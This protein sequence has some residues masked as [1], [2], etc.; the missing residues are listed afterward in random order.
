MDGFALRGADNDGK[1]YFLKEAVSGGNENPKF[2]DN[3]VTIETID[4]RMY[5]DDPVLTFEDSMVYG[6]TLDLNLDE[7]IDFCK[8]NK[9]KN[10]MLFQN[11]L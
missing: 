5:Y 4:Q 7:L 2:D 6:C 8:N 9:W 11:I 10:L 1:C 3:D